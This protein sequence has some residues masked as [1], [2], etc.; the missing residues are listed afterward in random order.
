MHWENYPGI[1]FYHQIPGVGISKPVIR[2]H[3]FQPIMVNDRGIK[4]EGQQWGA[5]SWVLK[6]TPSI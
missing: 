3:E 2:G 4:Q 1:Q 6:L 5:D